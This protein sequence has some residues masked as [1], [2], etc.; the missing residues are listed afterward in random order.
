MI[1]AQTIKKNVDEIKHQIEFELYYNK[2]KVYR[3]PVDALQVNN[4]LASRIASTVKW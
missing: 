1:L 2:T 4:D 3:W